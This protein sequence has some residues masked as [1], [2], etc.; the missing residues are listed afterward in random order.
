M[1]EVGH[2]AF[3]NCSTNKKIIANET[4]ANWFAFICVDTCKEKCMIREMTKYQPIE[5]KC[6]FTNPQEFEFATLKEYSANYTRPMFRAL[7]FDM[8]DIHKYDDLF[9]KLIDSFIK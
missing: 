2:M 6:Y 9:K 5:Y 1:H 8:I 7:K 4:L 3:T